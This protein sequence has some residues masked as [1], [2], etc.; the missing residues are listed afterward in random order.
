M[1]HQ[2]WHNFLKKKK[3]HLPIARQL[4]WQYIA[5]TILLLLTADASFKIFDEL[6]ELVAA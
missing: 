6:L 5:S 4:T 1:N 3:N 2:N